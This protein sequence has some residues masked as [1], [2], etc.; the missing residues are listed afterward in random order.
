MDPVKLK[1]QILSILF[2][3]SNPV[4]IK[5]IQE[6]LGVNEDEIKIVIEELVAA[7]HSSGIILLAHNN[8][9][10]LASNPDNTQVV[11]KFLSLELR[12][13]LTD[14]ALETLA[15]ITYKQPVSKAEVENIRG[16]NSQY[17]LRQLLI[18]G[19][20]E[21]I[22]SSSDK[23]MQL[24]KTTLEFMQHLGIKSQNEL[25]N[26]EELTKNI[27]LTPQAPP[28]AKIEI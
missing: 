24:Y 3:A 19:L 12:E 6:S 20:I 26:F 1:S 9:L 7:N 15:I 21:K 17:I 11:K 4:S 8:K 23:R 27:T 28:E 13:R 10:Q 25:P 18:R 22:P 2:V 14:S 16:V 5:E